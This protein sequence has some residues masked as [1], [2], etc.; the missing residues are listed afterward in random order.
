ME[1][2]KII[3]T[4]LFLVFFIFITYI[5]YKVLNH[6]PKNREVKDKSNYIWVPFMDIYYYFKYIFRK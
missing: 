6:L 4:I 2:F 5:K 3:L 1:N